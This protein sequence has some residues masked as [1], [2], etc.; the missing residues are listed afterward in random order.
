MAGSTMNPEVKAKWVAALRSGKYEQGTKTLRSQGNK[1]CCYGVLCELAVEAGVIYPAR[2][3]SFWP[4]YIY[5][6]R[7]AMPSGQVL[8]WARLDEPKVTIDGREASLQSHNDGGKT[9]T[10]IAD[11]IEA[12]L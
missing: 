11:A 8:A 2:L 6:S 12:Q 10:Q 7:T 9:F 1:F 4:D 5:D 3:S